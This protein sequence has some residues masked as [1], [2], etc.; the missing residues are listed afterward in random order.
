MWFIEF[1]LRGKKP[2][3][4]TEMFAL[5]A[6]FEHAPCVRRGPKIA[7]GNVNASVGF[8]EGFAEVNG[9]FVRT[10]AKFKRI[11]K[12]IQ[13]PRSDTVTIYIKDGELM[14]PFHRLGWPKRNSTDAKFTLR[15]IV[16]FQLRKW[17]QSNVQNLAYFIKAWFFAIAFK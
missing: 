5:R 12:D 7:I 13:L 1:L 9:C 14:S 11:K 3:A 8:A 2:D 16:P 4:L 6:T 15:E 10:N 17:Y